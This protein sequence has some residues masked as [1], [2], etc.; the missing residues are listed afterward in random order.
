MIDGITILNQTEIMEV[1][2]VW[3]FITICISLVIGFIVA[4]LLH[5]EDAL[6]IVTLL[7][8]IGMAI[9]VSILFKE[10]TGRYKYEC[11]IDDSVSITELYEKYEVIEQRGDIWVLEDKE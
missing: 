9:V 2:G 4:L 1:P 6:P 11:L 10:P 3:L 5:N 8:F 7:A